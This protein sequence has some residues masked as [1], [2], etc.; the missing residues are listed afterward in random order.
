MQHLKTAD[1]YKQFLTDLLSPLE[2]AECANRWAIASLLMEGQ[3][4]AEIAKFL[5]VSSATITR[6]NACLQQG[7][8]GYKRVWEK[9]RE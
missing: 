9:L 4:Q 8:G 6:V 2:L 7:R 5:G 1:D 3:K